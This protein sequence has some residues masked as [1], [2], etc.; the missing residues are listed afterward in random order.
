MSGDE[1]LRRFEAAARK[2]GVARGDIT[3]AVEYYRE[4]IDDR[5]EDHMS[6][7]DIVAALGSVDEAVRAI[8]ESLPPFR[9][10]VAEIRKSRKRTAIAVVLLVLGTVVWVPVAF[11]LAATAV[12]VYLVLWVLVGCVWMLDGVGFLLGVLA[13]PTLVHGATSGVP[14]AGLA[15]AGLFVVAGG[16][17]VLLIPLAAS[18]GDRLSHVALRFGHWVAHFF[19]RVRGGEENWGQKT[20]A[21]T[22]WRVRHAR[23]SG[24]LLRAGLVVAAIGA[25]LFLVSWG[26]AG[27]DLSALTALPPMA[28]PFG[29]PVT[30]GG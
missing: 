2:A 17:A 14:E 5:I 22:P 30:F 28:M 6:E 16:I 19:V 21:G 26:A 1:W 8:R 11:G 15:W 3:E 7:E 4:A 12:I 13:I 23:T 18:S 9:R 29:P 25:V 20:P 10:A 24:T 27:F